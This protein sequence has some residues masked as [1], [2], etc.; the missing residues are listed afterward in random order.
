M[1]RK[2]E[3]S[4]ALLARRQ[5]VLQALVAEKLAVFSGV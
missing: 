4:L 2:D 5:V 1:A 3:H